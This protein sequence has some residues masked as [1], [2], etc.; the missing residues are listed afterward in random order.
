MEA[1]ER[2][3]RD[4]LHDLLDAKLFMV[5]EKELEKELVL[6]ERELTEMSNKVT[7]DIGSHT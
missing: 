2:G 5:G 1:A 7:H 4:T 3:S 6:R